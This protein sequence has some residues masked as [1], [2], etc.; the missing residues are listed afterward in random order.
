MKDRVA[1]V[2]DGGYV[3]KR[4]MEEAREKSQNRGFPKVAEVVALTPRIMGHERLKTD[5]LFRVFFYDAPPYEGTSTN[6]INAKKIDFSQTREAQQNRALLDD[7]EKQPDFAVRRGVLAN[8][9]WKLGRYAFGRLRSGGNLRPRDLVPDFEQKG[10]DLRIGL[11]IASIAL[12]GA[13]GVIVVV[14]G[15]SDLIPAIKFAKKEGLRVYVEP[16]GGPIR[17]ELRAHADFVF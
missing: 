9:G 2:L 15:D 7:L 6:P 16:L 12:K 4:L 14:S 8:R 3:K 5:E 17:P 11:D 1:I 10:V 13:V